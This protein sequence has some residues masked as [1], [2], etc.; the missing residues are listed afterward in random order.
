MQ[1]ILLLRAPFCMWYYKAREVVCMKNRGYS[2]KGFFG[3]VN[4]Y[5]EYGR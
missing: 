5:D 2:R 4:H 1:G 3:Q